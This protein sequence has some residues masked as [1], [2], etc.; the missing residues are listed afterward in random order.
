M[1]YN[2]KKINYLF[3]IFIFV[4]GNLIAF[5]RGSNFS[6]A[7]AY[8]VI[9]AYINYFI[10]GFTHP[11]EVVSHPIPE[12]LI[13]FLSYNFGTPISNIFVFLVFLFIILFYKAF[14]NLEKMLCFFFFSVV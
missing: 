8:S 11:L 10:E 1:I 9:M 14:F 5:N 12:L 2:F 3:L 4:F 13:G 6:D 7:D